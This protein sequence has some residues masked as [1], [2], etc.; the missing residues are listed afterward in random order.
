MHKYILKRSITCIVAVFLISIIAFGLLNALPGKPADIIVKNVF[1]GFDA[2]LTSEELHEVSKR[3]D[4]ERPLYAQYATWLYNATVYQ[5]LGKSY[6]YSLPVLQLILNRLPATMKLAVVSILIVAIFGILI[7]IYAG[8][9]EGTLIDKIIRIISIFEVSFPNFW[10]A[11]LLIIIFSLTLKLVPSMGYKG[12]QCMILP[13]AALSCHP[14]AVIIRVTRT[15][16]LETLSQPYIQFAKAKGLS[17]NSI[18]K[19]HILKN[20]LIPVFTII[21]IQFGNM[22]AGTMIIESIFAWPGIGSLL[23]DAIN[24]RDFPLVVGLI[25]TIV[26]MILI[27]N[28]IVD[29]ICAYIDP[30][31]RY[32]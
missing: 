2:E 22:L 25:V 14:L 10:V 7:G 8:F 13:V 16:V 15:S 21:G 11:L 5:D 9:H 18:I 30:R 24:G 17:W 29:L 3:Y 19:R 26:S 23:I 4:L 12:I 20:A 31:I 1:T 32:E 28:F 6:L 27:V